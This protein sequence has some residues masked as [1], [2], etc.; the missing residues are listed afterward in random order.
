MCITVNIIS[1]SREIG[2]NQ[3]FAKLPVKILILYMPTGKPNPRYI[4]LEFW[5]ENPVIVL[6]I[7]KVF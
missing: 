4:K 7:L 2:L 3:W 5:G 6:K 1:A